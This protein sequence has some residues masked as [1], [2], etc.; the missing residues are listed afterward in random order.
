MK[1]FKSLLLIFVTL[2]FVISAGCFKKDVM[3]DT[4]DDV[5]EV[6]IMDAGG[7]KV[8]VTREE[9]FQATSKE[10]GRGITRTSGYTEYRLNSYNLNTGELIARIDLGERDDNNYYL[11]GPADG[12]LWYVS[13]DKE[14]GLHARDPKTLE[15]IVPQSEIISKN[16]NLADNL[17]H[18]QYYEYRKYY[19]YDDKLKLPMISDNSGYVYYL[20]P[21]TLKTEKTDKSI[22]AYKYDESAKT[23]SMEFISGIYLNLSGDPRKIL[24]VK[25]SDYPELSFLDGNFMFSTTKL[26]LSEIN[27]D[28][29]APINKEIEKYKREIDSLNN[30]LDEYNKSGLSESDYRIRSVGYSIENAKRQIKYK[31]EEK[32]RKDTRSNVLITEDRGFFIIHKSNATDTAKVIISK[33]VIDDNLKPEKKW[34]TIL[35]NVFYDPGKVIATSGFEYVFS[36]GNP[37]LSTVRILYGEGKLVFIFMMRCVC[38]DGKT[39]EILWDIEL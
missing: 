35:Q 30:L 32:E 18:P 16:P 36:K 3:V 5:E 20:D 37:D 12:K 28:F 19:G 4:A 9:I 2:T 24:R 31:E 34:E 26:S 10:S 7:E 23:T 38:I 15:I 17:P 21:K 8:L 39:G 22:E 33:I 27:P 11:L 29:F 1:I 6:L 25:S 14:T 13:S